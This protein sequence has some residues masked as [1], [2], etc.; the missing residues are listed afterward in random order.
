M[1]RPI[2]APVDVLAIMA[3]PD[4]AELLCG[5]ALSKAAASGA[6]KIAANAGKPSPNRRKKSPF[7]VMPS[8]EVDLGRTIAVAGSVVFMKS[9]ITR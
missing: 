4:D 5:G 1:K 6:I 9:P 2:S 7:I 3:H 8:P